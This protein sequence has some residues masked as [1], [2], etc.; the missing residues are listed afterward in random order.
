MQNR[1]KSR[2]KCA[3]PFLVKSRLFGV[4]PDQFLKKKSGS[5]P[6]S[7]KNGPNGSTDISCSYPVSSHSILSIYSHQQ[8]FPSIPLFVT[9]SPYPCI[10]ILL[11]MTISLYPHPFI[12][13][14]LSVSLYPSIHI[15]L[16]LLLFPFTFIHNPVSLS[17]YEQVQ[18]GPGL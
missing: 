10:P 6:K 2:P 3:L 8:P 16:S 5:G 4:N 12:L 18:A 15:L 9:K 11:S 17:L 13:I 1:T 14:P 7:G